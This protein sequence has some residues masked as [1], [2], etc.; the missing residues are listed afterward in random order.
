MHMTIAQLMFH[1]YMQLTNCNGFQ[2]HEICANLMALFTT[3]NS[4]GSILQC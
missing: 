1:E 2:K 3:L 4:G